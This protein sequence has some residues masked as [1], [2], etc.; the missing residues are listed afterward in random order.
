MGVEIIAI[1]SSDW[2][3]WVEAAASFGEIEYNS[4]ASL[5]SGVVD[6]A[7]GRKVKLLHVQAHGS[8]AG[9]NLGTG[10]IGMRNLPTFRPLLSRLNPLWDADPWVDLRACSVGQNLP[11]VAAL[12]AMWG[13]TIV[14]GRGRQNNLLDMNIGR[15]VTVK[16]DGTHESSF[17]VPPQVQ[18]NVVRR[19]WR[20]A[21][22]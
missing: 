20:E 22:S 10:Q 6:Y 15:Y 13:T 5:V 21:A 4:P 14:A 12:A 3:G 18:Y 1:E 8:A 7:S 9:I 16:P 17:F 19:A 11:F 2:V